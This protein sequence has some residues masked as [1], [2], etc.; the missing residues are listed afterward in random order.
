MILGYPFLCCKQFFQY[1]LPG[2]VY[3]VEVSFLLSFLFCSCLSLSFVYDLFQCNWV[4]GV[5]VLRYACRIL[6][7]TLAPG[8]YI[9]SPAIIPGFDATIYYYYVPVPGTVYNPA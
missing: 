5:R 1:T 2:T 8:Y 7:Y 9:S 4:A 3:S 6:L